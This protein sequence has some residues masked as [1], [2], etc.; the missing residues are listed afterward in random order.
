MISWLRQAVLQ[1]CF[2]LFLIIFSTNCTIVFKDK[3][4]V[5]M[6]VNVLS[7]YHSAEE[8]K[9]IFISSFHC[10]FEVTVISKLVFAVFFVKLTSS[11]TMM[12]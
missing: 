5:C 7:Q 1:N 8:L 11:I 12:K 3:I 4:S 9:S 6:K 10:C 2:R